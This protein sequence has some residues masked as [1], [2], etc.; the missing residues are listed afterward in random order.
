MAEVV[1]LRDMEWRNMGFGGS[2]DPKCEACR[3]TMRNSLTVNVRVV[4]EK[5]SPLKRE[6]HSRCRDRLLRRYAAA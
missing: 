4:R 2:T 1:V 5:N 3:R 6:I